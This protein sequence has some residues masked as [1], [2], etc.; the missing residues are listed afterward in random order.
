MNIE[1]VISGLR[2]G[3]HLWFAEEGTEIPSE[4]NALVSRTKIPSGENADVG[5]WLKIGKISKV[6]C[7]VS[8]TTVTTEEPN[9]CNL[10]VSEEDVVKVERDYT[11]I[12]Q[13]PSVV[14]FE[15]IFGTKLDSNGEGVIDSYPAKRGWLIWAGVAKDKTQKIIMNIWCNLTVDGSVDF[16]SE[17]FTKPTLKAKQL[18]SPLTNKI[19]YI[20]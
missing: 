10:E 13:E 8:Q 20:V 1:N 19:K 7:N 12:V 16:G 4:G 17:D 18:T 6:T 14:A 5:C 3:P 2:V 15:V 9:P 11:L